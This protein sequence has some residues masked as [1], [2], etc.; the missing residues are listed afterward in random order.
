M[1]DIDPESRL[2]TIAS[3][4]ALGETVD[5]IDLTEVRTVDL[6]VTGKFNGVDLDGDLVFTDSTQTLENKTLIAPTLN[7]VSITGGFMTGVDIDGGTI[8]GANIDGVTMVNVN[9]DQLEAG[10]IAAENIAVTGYINEDAA[11]DIVF[12]NKSQTLENKTLEAPILNSP[13]INDATINSST[14]DSP[15][16]TT[17]TLE[18]PVL[19]NVTITGGTM[20]GV[21]IDGGSINGIS[22][23]NFVTL[24]GTQT[25]SNKTLTNP[26]I[27]GFLNGT[28]IDNYVTTFGIQTL[29]NKTLS[30]PTISGNLNGTPIGNFVTTTGTQTLTNKTLTSPTISVP[31]IGGGNFVAPTI[32]DPTIIGGIFGGIPMNAE[33]TGWQTFNFEHGSNT[34]IPLNLKFTKFMGVVFVQ[35]DHSTHS[36]TFPNAPGSATNIAMHNIPTFFGTSVRATHPANVING[37]PSSS[38]PPTG[39]VNV[40]SSTIAFYLGPGSTNFKNVAGNGIYRFAIHYFLG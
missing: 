30:N 29:S 23:S 25:L 34:P 7:D 28:G 32:S 35:S 38:D 2:F 24:A 36:I 39:S 20:S 4:D 11:S 37:S 19:N 3:G 40:L 22:P 33:T 14:L 31:T 26:T 27:S 6:Y 12:T 5:K 9:I 15:T 18:S 21:D 10:N 17:A 8:Y 1:A 13:T 16:L